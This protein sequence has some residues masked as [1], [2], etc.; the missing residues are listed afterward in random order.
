MRRRAGKFIMSSRP[1]S[2]SRPLE[3]T[4]AH[5]EKLRA[6][7]DRGR[8]F[9]FGIW[10]R[11]DGA[12]VGGLG[13]H[14]RS[15]SGSYEVGY[16]IAGDRTGRGY[17]TEAAGAAIRVAFEVLGAERVEIHVQPENVASMRVPERLGFRRVSLERNRLQWRD[18]TWRDEVKWVLRDADLAEAP[19]GGVPYE[20]LGAVSGR[21]AEALP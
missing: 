19:A 2:R 9:S 5:L 4:A 13:I 7:F 21:A 6:E 17:A 8:D 3:K 15:G 10:D 16:W 14:P 20:V 11:S 18:G 1:H 12:L